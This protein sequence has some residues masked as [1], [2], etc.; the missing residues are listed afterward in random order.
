[1]SSLPPKFTVPARAG[2]TLA[3][4]LTVMAVIIVLMALAFP[5]FN[6]IKSSGDLTKGISDV[7]GTLELARTYALANNTY[8]WV[9]FYEE[10]GSQ[11]SPNTS[12]NTN[13]GRLI[14]SVVASRDGTRYSDAGIPPKRFGSGDSSNLTTLIQINKL[15]KL[16]G[17]H[18][19]AANDPSGNANSPPRPSVPFAYQ[20]GDASGASTNNGGGVF[21]DTTLSPSGNT[22]TFTY[23]VPPAAV[24]AYTFTKIIEFSPQGE[25]SKIT[26]NSFGGAGVQSFMEIALQPTHGNAVDG[27][28]ADTTKAA[29]AIQVEGITGQVKIYRP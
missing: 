14:L 16:D 11:S 15:V 29:A 17:V 4:L 3:E 22:A 12:P 2:F 24:P 13:G 27:H 28:Y 5:A 25:A 8:V 26:E 7:A 9:G 6:S 18:L 10:D 1:M 21:A 20:V 19:I 23:P